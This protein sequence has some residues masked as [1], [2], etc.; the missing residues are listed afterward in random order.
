MSYKEEKLY[1][2]LK[3]KVHSS[4]SQDQQFVE[5]YETFISNQAKIR[6]HLVSQN[7]VGVVVSGAKSNSSISN[8]TA[9]VISFLCFYFFLLIILYTRLT[10]C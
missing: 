9:Q 2:A 6:D 4:V 7:R 8:D 3:A 5:E 1:I 10:R